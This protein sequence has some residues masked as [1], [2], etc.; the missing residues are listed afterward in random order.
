MTILEEITRM[1]NQGIKDEEIVNSL[2][3]QGISPREINDALNQAQIKSAV[4]GTVPSE[5]MQ[6]SIMEQGTPPQS[7]SQQ[8]QATYTPQTQEIPEGQMYAPQ[9][10]YA[11]PQ[12]AYQ[13]E[14]YGE[15][16]PGERSDSDTM[17]EIAEQVFSEK[18]KKMQKK[19]E[20]VNEFKTLAE[21]KIDNI[22]RRLKRIETIIDRLQI[23]ILDKIGSYGKNL[24]SIKKEMSMMQDSFGKMINP[25]ADKVE[26]KLSHKIPH[27]KTTHPRKKTSKK[28]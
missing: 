9:Q 21:V 13:Q 18:I 8:A 19:V 24:E 3:Q 10:G 14:A 16:V 28:K 27:H 23:S 25:L 11:Q 5:G 20:E 2:Q 6:P 7:P 17:I 4:S 26:K 15:Y 12:D 22:A 1:K